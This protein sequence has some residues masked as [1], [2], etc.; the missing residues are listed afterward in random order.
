MMQTEFAFRQRVGKLDWKQISSVNIENIYHHFK[1]Q[2]L[3]VI[4]DLVTFSEFTNEDV[5]NNTIDS[6]SLLVRLMQLIIEYLLH[7]QEMQYRSIRELNKQSEGLTHNLQKLKRKNMVLCE[8]A[9]IYQRQIAMMRKSLTNV[10]NIDGDRDTHGIEDRV[11]PKI[12]NLSNNNNSKKEEVEPTNKSNNQMDSAL[13]L[14]SIFKHERETRSFMAS[15]MEEQRNSFQNE[16]TKLI[17][18]IMTVPT[19]PLN[20]SNNNS[21]NSNNDNENMIRQSTNDLLNKFQQKIE[22]TL[23]TTLISIQEKKQNIN[24]QENNK[25]DTRKSN[26]NQNQMEVM[27]KQAALE[28]YENEL[29]QRDQELFKREARLLIN[30]QNKKQSTDTSSN[31]RPNEAFILN[32]MKLFG[33]KTI[34]RVFAHVLFKKKI[35]YFHFWYNYIIQSRDSEQLQEQSRLLSIGST[36]Q[37]ESE[38][39]WNSLIKQEKDKN[40][41]ALTRVDL[42]TRDLTNS[43]DEIKKLQNDIKN[44]MNQTNDYDIILKQEKEKMV[45]MEARYTIAL[46]RLEAENNNYLVKIRELENNHNLN[47]SQQL[48]SSS[49]KQPLNMPSN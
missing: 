40:L 26:N 1:I 39:K 25:N 47:K 48:L 46:A 14:D 35:K 36:I 6:L 21:N 31:S 11:P 3:Q 49:L 15:F 4:V 7:S 2:E 28:S 44:Q 37:K 12:I 41:V 13:L 43:R 10:N 8:D 34:V 5:K 19:L 29:N 32:K 33:L 45:S 27:L 42:L 38:S 17:D 16:I 9:K 23:E 24:N 18:K 20:T 22:S 30:S